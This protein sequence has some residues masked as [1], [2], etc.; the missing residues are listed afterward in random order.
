M[1]KVGNAEAEWSGECS[2]LCHG[3][4]TLKVDGEDVSEKIPESLKQNHM[5]TYKSYQKWHFNED[6]CE[7]W[8][9]YN[10]GLRCED[11]IE[12]NGYWLNKIVADKDIQ[13][14]VFYAINEED[15]RHGSCGGCI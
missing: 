8:E 4:W 1:G 11:W 10:D 13:K 7:E 14:C 15:W 2:C 12:V 3:K 9:S 6:Y 5:S